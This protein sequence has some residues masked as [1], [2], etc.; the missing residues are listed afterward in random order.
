[1]KKAAPKPTSPAAESAP[2]KKART[3]GKPEHVPTP[4]TRNLVQLAMLNDMTHKQA[5]KLVGIN[6]ETLRRR[7]PDELE[8]GKARLLSMVAANLYRIAQ[9]Q[10]DLKAALT[11]S[12]FV[13]KSKGGW[14]D[15]AAQADAEVEAPGGIKVR[16]RIGDRP[17]EGA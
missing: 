14:N 1:M 17:T 3:G 11:A 10:G 9:Q 5:A 4:Q 12:I 8:H 7:Y 16:L 6:E 2:P 15:R 13:L